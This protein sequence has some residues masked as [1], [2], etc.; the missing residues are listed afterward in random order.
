MVQIDTVQYKY[1]EEKI[2][3]KSWLKVNLL[4]KNIV[5][6]DLITYY[7]SLLSLCFFVDDNSPTDGINPDDSLKIKVLKGKI[8]DM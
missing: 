2:Y 3:K 5:Y 1:K 7:T 8:L 4:H 6:S